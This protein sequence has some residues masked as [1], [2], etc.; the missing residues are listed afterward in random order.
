MAKQKVQRQFYGTTEIATIL[1]V[2][3]TKARTLMYMFGQHGKLLRCGKL[4]R[5]PVREFEEY[6][7]QNMSRAGI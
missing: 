1:G 7:K 3:D 2:S 5:V 6:I 4:L